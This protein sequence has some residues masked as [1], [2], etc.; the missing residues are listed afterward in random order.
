[1]RHPNSGLPEFG[2]IIVQVG[3]SRLGC[4]GPESIN[5]DRGYGF[6]ARFSK[7]AVADWE[8][9]PGMTNKI[10]YRNSF[11]GSFEVS[12]SRSSTIDERTWAT[13]RCGISTLLTMSDR[14]F[15]SRNTTFSR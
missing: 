9:R 15:R 1:M 7:P 5:A 11:N 10:F 14:L 3:N 12:F 2:I 6:R 13:L 4:A 8:V